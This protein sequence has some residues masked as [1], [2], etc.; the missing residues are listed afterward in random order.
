MFSKRKESL[1]EVPVNKKGTSNSNA[2]V[3]AGL[4]DSAVTYTGKGALAYSTTDNDFVDQFGSVGQFLAPRDYKDIAKDMGILYMQ[5]KEKAVKFT[6]YLRLISR[7]CKTFD[8]EVTEN[9]QRGAGLK[10]ESIMRMVWLHTNDE[11]AFWDNIGLFI[12]VGSWKDVFEMMRTDLEFN[13]FNDKVLNW[14]RMSALISAG[15]QNKETSEL[16]KKYLPQITAKSKCT[17]VRKQANTIIGKYI[18]NRL[19]G[20][21]SYKKY[22]KLKSSGSA[23]VWQQLISKQLFKDIDFDTVHGR[24]LSAMVSGNFLKNNDLEDVYIKWIESKPVAKF[25]GYVHELANN[26]N[27]PNYTCKYSK[28][29][30]PYKAMTINKQ[31][32][33]LVELA[34]DGVNTNSGLIVVRDTSSSMTSTAKG[35]NM[36]SY[37]IGK[38]LG[39]FF[40]DMLDGEFSNTWIEFNS[41]AKLHKYKGTTFV[42]K[43]MSDSSESYGSTNFMSIIHLFN[44]LKLKGVD[45]KDFPTGMICISDGELNPASLS[46][47]NIEE[48]RIQLMRGGFSKEYVKNFKFV[49]WNIPNGYYRDS[50]T[51]FQTFG[52][53]KNVFYLSGYDGS[54]LSF[55]L[56][57]TDMVDEK[58]N[59]IEQPKTDVE[60]FETAM[61]Q[62]ILNLVKIN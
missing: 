48:A 56:G 42:D 19:F 60:L 55:L 51:K 3:N 29:L 12:A 32:Q 10:Y 34:K 43:W 35:S 2:F 20:E 54:I 53:T 44:A 11:N 18:S 31:Y 17:T 4:K 61:N 36:S 27:V 30:A 16:V 41:N 24:A 39:I 8:G 14:E 6:L 1:F 13:G 33:G 40:G 37:D 22:R 45:E 46:N 25:T 49:M 15:L 59:V 28:P 23:H 7:K 58:G 5:D 57:G 50:D 9:V 62:E 47:T 21:N 38:A 52:E 26:I